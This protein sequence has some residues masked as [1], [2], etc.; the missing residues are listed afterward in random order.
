MTRAVLHVV[1]GVLNDADGR[2]LIAQ[3]PPGKHLAG[4]W[5]F[6][7]GKRDDDEPREAALAR[8][9]QEELDVEVLSARPLIRYTHDYPDRRVDLDV[10]LITA[11]RGEPRGLEGQAIDWCAPARLMEHDLLPADKP[12]VT[13][14]MLSPLCVVTGVFADADEFAR[15]L[16]GALAAGA[17][18]VQLRVPGAGTDELVALGAVAS[19]LT[20]GRGARLVVNAAPDQWPALR[21]SRHFDG[22]HLAARHAASAGARPVEP[23]VLLGVSCHD[24]AELARAAA[25]GADYAVLG[26]VRPTASHPGDP[27]LGW[28]RFAGLVEPCRLPVYAIGGMTPADRP[29]AWDAGAQGVA[30][31]G[32]L[33]QPGSGHRRR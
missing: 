26:S 27:T 18:L 7:G 22:L 15:R 3:R 19:R 32:G 23:D 20:S 33:W 30:A 9:F 11:H 31:I 5:E 6:P 17:G 13:A 29:R 10:W 21:A 24:G 8:E 4:G 25:L 12:I 16:A 14:L 2:V 1:A 28:H